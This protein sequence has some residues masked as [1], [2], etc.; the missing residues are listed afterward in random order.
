VAKRYKED[1]L[2]SVP[3][4]LIVKTAVTSQ[5][6]RLSE[7]EEGP[8]SSWSTGIAEVALPSSYRQRNIIETEKAATSKRQEE[9]ERDRLVKILQGN[10]LNR[11]ES[12]SMRF[13]RFELGA[14]KNVDS[15]SAL[16]PN[17]EGRSII[18]SSETYLPG[19]SMFDLLDNNSGSRRKR[20]YN[21]D[22]IVMAKFRKVIIF[23]HIIINCLLFI[24]I[25]CK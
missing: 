14:D 23:L 5:K 17:V 7:S 21:S 3:E 6:V 22:D 9:E 11:N 12:D 24:F 13:G 10:R 20:Q 18:S 2:Y 8:G 19:S 25:L 16:L 4:D 15:L 1:E